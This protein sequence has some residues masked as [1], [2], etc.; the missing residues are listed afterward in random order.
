LAC[1]RQSRSSDKSS[2]RR[3]G[4]SDHERCDQTSPSGLA[5]LPFRSESCHGSAM[6]SAWPSPRQGRGAHSNCPTSA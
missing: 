2:R 1:R 3:A 5:S 4:R 6:R